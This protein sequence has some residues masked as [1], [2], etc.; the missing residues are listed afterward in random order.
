MR[1]NK[2]L[3]SR[4]NLSRRKADSLILSST[5]TVDGCIAKIGDQVTDTN[6]ILVDQKPLPKVQ[7]LHLIMLNK[8]KGFVCSRRGQ[9][10]KTIFNLL[11]QNY[12]N[13][14]PIGRLD[15]DSSGLLLLSN[16]GDLH[17]KLA[18]PASG[19]IKKYLV[20]LNKP[21]NDKDIIRLNKGVTLQDG[22]SRL[23]TSRTDKSLD[24][25]MTEG[26]KRQIRRTFEMIGYRVIALHRYQFGPYVLNGLGS[27]KIKVIY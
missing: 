15:K 1:L 14:N 2:L 24:I 25:S 10:S 27:S 23:I 5:V 18:H 13:L 17:Q 22:L 16:D 11:P 21:I 9:G 12:H 7:A 26:R 19:K 20:T 4:L 6:I 8:P 3:A